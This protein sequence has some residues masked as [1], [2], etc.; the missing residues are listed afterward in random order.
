MK[1]SLAQSFTAEERREYIGASE[2]AAIMC[3]DRYRT[4][5]DVYNIKV[6]LS[7]P[8]EGNNHTERGNNLE[9][10]AANYYTEKTG[11]KLRRHNEG[12]VDKEFPMVRGHLDRMVVGEKRLIEIKCPSV[13]AFRRLQRDGLPDS[14]IIQAQ[15]Y[16]RLSGVPRLTWV[17]FC[18]DAWDAATFDIDYDADVAA[19]AFKAA[20]DFWRDHIEPQIPP[21]ETAAEQK[22]N[23]ELAKI[24][25]FATDRDD[26]AFVDAAA[27]LREA[28]DLAREAGELL[29]SAKADVLAVIEGIPGIY[30]GGGLRLHYTE[31]AGRKSF[32]KKAAAADG[33]DLSKYEKVGNP[34]PVFR[35]YFLNQ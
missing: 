29:E 18:A 22:V 6:G 10:I 14:F 11:I 19:V 32:D 31:Q 33:I 8:F 23:F 15:A 25:G 17:I 7:A 13:A 3:L 9:A 5:L 21:V 20:A 26:Q 30:Q 1:S 12:F 34:F 2:I 28:T 16:M 4:P 24:G 27:R 35:P